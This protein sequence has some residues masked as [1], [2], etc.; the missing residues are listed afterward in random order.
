MTQHDRQALALC[1]HA[2]RVD[3]LRGMAQ[4]IERLR[5]QFQVAGLDL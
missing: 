3:P 1:A 2:V 5:Q 4:R